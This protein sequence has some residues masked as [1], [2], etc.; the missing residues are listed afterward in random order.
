MSAQVRNT[1]I[2]KLKRDIIVVNRVRRP[3]QFKEFLTELT[4]EKEVFETYKDALV[5]AA[6]LGFNRG[7]RV[8]FEKT[9]EPIN[10]QIFRDQFDEMVMNVLAIAETD[11][12]FVIAKDRE[13]EK[14]RIFEEYACGGLEIMQNEIGHGSLDESL[15]AII[16][17]E[18]ESEGILGEIKG[19]A[20]L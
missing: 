6:C 13:T 19:L 3:E 20:K 9:S 4:K 14:I 12:P 8:S 18:E 5:F 11:Q 10:I 7:K 1:N 15:L 17:E 2:P 16:L